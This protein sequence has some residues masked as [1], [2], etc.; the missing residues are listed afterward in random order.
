MSSAAIRRTS[1]FALGLC[2]LAGCGGGSG[3]SPAASG[4]STASIGQAIV[5]Y[6][7]Q[8]KPQLTASSGSVTVTSLSGASITGLTLYPP[9]SLQNTYIFFGRTVGALSE[10]FR[11]PY[12]A[13]AG[14]T[15]QLL[16]RSEEQ[17][18]E[19]APAAN[20]T[21]F[22]SGYYGEIPGE[23]SYDGTHVQSF[24]PGGP[25][26]FLYPNV[27][28]NEAQIAFDTT[29][30]QE[31]F[32]CSTAGGSAKQVTGAT[33][34]S[35]GC[36]WAPTNESIAYVSQNASDQLNIYTIPSA[37]G[38]PT[39]VSPK[40]LQT[41][42]NF[43]SP[44]WS[45]DGV[46]IAASCVPTSGTTNSEVLVFN[47]NT[48]YTGYANM[49]PSGMSDTYPSFSPDGSKVAFYRSKTGGATPGIYV[50]DY[51]GTNEQLLV[52]DQSADGAVN[53]LTWSP[54]PSAE[55]EIGT[56]GH[57]YAKN[58]TGF[59]YAQV[60]AQFGSLVAFTTTTPSTATV[61]TPSTATGGQPLSFLITGDNITSLG[62]SDSY[63]ST[64][65]T[66]TYTGT[67]PDAVVTIDATTGQVDAVA[68]A[69]AKPA[70]TSSSGHLTYSGK[71][72][73]IYDNTGKN[74]TP[75]G[76]TQLVVDTKTGH[77]V[78]YK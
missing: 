55:K 47:T 71:F 64:G 78:S 3:G 52:A 25:G 43:Y 4:G 13:G 63:F 29:S 2:F 12:T 75:T 65:L 14:G 16:S 45:S 76:A 27:S 73:A 38:T 34:D 30:Y 70:L 41:T 1:I 57:F 11:V 53:S 60:G 19:P 35:F 18:D 24:S 67:N 39:D 48:F 20:G 46:S 66:Y 23:M 32:V 33:D 22:Y 37:G 51:D 59:L 5:T 56:G 72:N 26:Y 61:S 77:L 74:L 54:F 7:G 17:I 50:A 21:V 36:S 40:A 68:L 44:S 6:F 62:Y 42:A 9:A 8:V 31:L 49:T 10:I 15:E 69:A 58:A 28:P